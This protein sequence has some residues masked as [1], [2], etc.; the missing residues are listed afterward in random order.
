VRSSVVSTRRARHGRTRLL[1]QSAIAGL[2]LPRPVASN[3]YPGWK[4]KLRAWSL[5]S[6]TPTHFVC[7][8]TFEAWDGER[9]IFSRSWEKKITRELV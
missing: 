4:V 2:A 3:D 6:S 7:S 5:C 1:C 8:E 9:S